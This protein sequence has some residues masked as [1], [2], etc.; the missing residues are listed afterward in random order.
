MAELFV[1]YPQ[2]RCSS[3]L[4][5]SIDL[6]AVMTGSNLPAMLI[7]FLA[8]LSLAQI[9]D[10]WPPQVPKVSPAVLLCEKRSSAS[11]TPISRASFNLA[12][13]C[14]LQIFCRTVMIFFR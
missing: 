14:T 2:G 6:V 4:D 11:L 9:I 8:N 12:T 1:Y 10:V 7:D 5:P 3:L 13:A